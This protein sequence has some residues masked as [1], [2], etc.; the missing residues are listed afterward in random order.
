MRERSKMPHRFR[1]IRRK[2]GTRTQGYGRVGQ[3]RKSGSQG[4][5]NPGRHKYLWS[6]VVS[7][8]P[9]YFEKRGFVSPRSLGRE[10]K[11]INVGE[12][13]EMT[14][15]ATE[16]KKTRTKAVVID[17]KELGYSKLLGKGKIT[18]PVH[19]KV[20]SWS[21]NAARKVEAAGGRVL[22]EEQPKS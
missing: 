16:T 13:E 3:H 8:E 10:S 17:L 5:R 2:R 9:D 4:R 12:L 14:P 20:G 11:T 18:K 22:T 19:V 6:Y 7:Y 21:E 1:K 15:K